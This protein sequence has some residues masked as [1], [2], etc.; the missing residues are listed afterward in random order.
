MDM[1]EHAVRIPTPAFPADAKKAISSP[2]VHEEN[3]VLRSRHRNDG[4]TRFSKFLE[5]SSLT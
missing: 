4:I 3:S 5:R 2:F 1:I